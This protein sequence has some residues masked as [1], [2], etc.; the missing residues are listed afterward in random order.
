M[1][2]NDKIEKLETKIQGV[3]ADSRYTRE[4]TKEQFQENDNKV[5]NFHRNLKEDTPQNNKG[6]LRKLFG[7]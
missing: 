5:N 4:E 7:R 6:I 2:S 3:T 1:Q